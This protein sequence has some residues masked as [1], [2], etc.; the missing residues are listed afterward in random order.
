MKKNLFCILTVAALL[1]ACE[2][3]NVPT[4]EKPKPQ[5]D[6]TSTTKPEDKP[7]VVEDIA[8]LCTPSPMAE[9]QRV[10]DYLIEQYGHHVLS[11]AMACVNWNTN[12]A[13]WV[14]YHT[15]KWPAMTCFDLIQATVEEDW[16]R[17]V[18]AS[19]ECYEDWWNNHGIVLG[20]WHEIVPKKEGAERK[21]GNL[22]YKPGETSFRCSH[23]VQEGTWENA[24]LME[25]LDRVAAVLKG[26]Q[27][28][29]IPVIWRPYHEAAGKWFW[30]G[31]DAESHK[32]LWRL[33][34]D[35][36]VKHH[37]LNNLIWVWTTQGGD[38]DWYPGDDVVD[39]V[40]CDIYKKASGSV[41]AA[42]FEKHRAAFPGKMITLSE[43]GK[44]GYWMAQLL[45]Q[46]Q[47][48]AHWSYFMPWYDNKRTQTA[49][50]YSTKFKDTETPHEQCDIEWWR[51]AW[52]TDCILSRD[53]LPAWK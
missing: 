15:G 52:E 7:V 3:K 41:F 28:R 51:A 31:Q 43:C 12:E 30:W 53:D 29:H 23:A 26:F 45:D 18:Y 16:A 21:S 20:M 11:G 25:D 10:Y 50:E 48:G 17:K 24:Y 37:G 9:T 49:S 42:D 32:A 14:H 13:Q 47:S 35:R 46:W 40:G 34:Y 22:T 39:I 27:E 4:G 33:M 6:T 44:S 19:Y 8:P 1:I 38:A 36:L 5:R 2:P